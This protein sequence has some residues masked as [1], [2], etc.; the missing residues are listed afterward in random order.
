HR[1]HRGRELGWFMALKQ[2]R[3]S[4]TNVDSNDSSR[5]QPIRPVWQGALIWIVGLVVL[6]VALAVVM[7]TA[8]LPALNGNPTAQSA[9]EAHLGALQTQ[10]ALTPL[11]TAATT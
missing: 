2:P 8:L 3:A 7:R 10:Q 5:A 9:A 6:L 4:G 1:H 11:P